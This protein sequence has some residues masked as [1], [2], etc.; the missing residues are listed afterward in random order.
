MK[1]R[2]QKPI[3]QNYTVNIEWCSS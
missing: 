3:Y 1:K 2:V